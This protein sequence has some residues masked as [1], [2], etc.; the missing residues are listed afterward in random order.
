MGENLF[1]KMVSYS[2]FPQSA[3]AA[4]SLSKVMAR[5]KGAGE[6]SL[7]IEIETEAHWKLLLRREGLIVVEVYAGWCGPCLSM[8]NILRKVKVD[9]NDDRLTLATV[10]SEN[11]AELRIFKGQSEPAWI[12]M[13]VEITPDRYLF[14][15][16]FIL[17]CEF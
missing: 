3:A 13:G 15:I 17:Y 14:Y 9:A 11:I 7:Q 6:V 4:I 8:V 1:K 16:I 12:F 10:N 2:S 5:K